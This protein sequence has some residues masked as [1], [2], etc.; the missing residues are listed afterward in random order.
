[1]RKQQKNSRQTSAFLACDNLTFF[2][3]EDTHP[4]LSDISFS[5]CQGEIM[6]ICGESGCGKTTLLRHMKKNQ[7]P[8]GEKQGE[9][10]LGGRSLEEIPLRESTEI[11]GFVGQNPQEQLV[12]DTVWHELAFAMEN[13][14]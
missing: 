5:V 7:M 11:I 12:T 2:Y 4:T 1:L 13:L 14:G 3:P 10:T 8:F 9:I 6:V